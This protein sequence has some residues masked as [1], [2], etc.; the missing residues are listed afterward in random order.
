MGHKKDLSHT[1][2]WGRSGTGWLSAQHAPRANLRL[3]FECLTLGMDGFCSFQNMKG[4]GGHWASFSQIL[5]KKALSLILRLL[6]FES[7]FWCAL[8][9]PSELQAVALLLSTFAE[10][11][12]TPHHATEVELQPLGPSPLGCSASLWT[13]VH[14]GT[15]W[16]EHSSLHRVRASGDHLHQLC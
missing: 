15:R 12:R 4:G 2:L 1:Y 9:V 8:W 14:K 5:S 6:V 3:S 7:S 16:S 13:Q 11:P 10:E